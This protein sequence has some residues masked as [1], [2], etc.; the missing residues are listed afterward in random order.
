MV[1]DMNCTRARVV[2]E[3]NKV[4][5]CSWTWTVQA[6]GLNQA[7]DCPRPRLARGHYVF[8]DCPR[9]WTER[10]RGQSEAIACTRPDRARG[11]SVAVDRSVANSANI[12]RFRRDFFADVRALWIQGVRR[13]LLNPQA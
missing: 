9:T 5:G 2:C 11:L 4:A 7:L 6:R 3:L 10:G 12:P 8:V 13:P 1:G